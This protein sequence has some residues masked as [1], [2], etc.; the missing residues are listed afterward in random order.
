MSQKVELNSF[1]HVLFQ[2]YKLKVK[3]LIWLLISNIFFLTNIPYSN[4]LKVSLLKLFGAKIGVKCIIK[5]WVKI[6]F[7]WELE[8]GNFVWLGEEVW[9]DNISKITI[10][11]NVCIS[12]GA[13]LITGNH[14][15][16]LTDFPLISKPIKIEDGVW[17]CAKAI[18]TGGVKVGTHAVLGMNLIASK[19][20]KAYTI[21]NSDGSTKDRNITK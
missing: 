12:Q 10:G 9:L 11:S 15:Y 21:Y 14:R 8:I 7:P 18:V 4:I 3:Y 20:L 17:I 13:L 2:N 1:R 16:D 6:K 5:P 19:D